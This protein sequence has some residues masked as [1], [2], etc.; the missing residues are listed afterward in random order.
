MHRDRK[1]S[2]G[3]WIRL[4]QLR[5][6][7]TG[8]GGSLGPLIAAELSDRLR[9]NPDEAEVRL[10]YV[11]RLAA[12]QEFARVNLINAVR[13]F[14]ADTVLMFNG[15]FVLDEVILSVARSEGL[16]VLRYEAGGDLRGFDLFTHSANDREALQRRM[17]PLIEIVRS[18]PRAREIGASWFETRV[19]QPE[20]MHARTADVGLTGE[21]VTF[22]TSSPDEF[23]LTRPE[24]MRG[25]LS[26]IDAIRAVRDSLATNG[27]PELVVRTH[28]N[29]RNKSPL[30]RKAWS[31]SLSGLTGIRV[32]D[33]EQS[34]DSYELAR[35]SKWV[36][37]YGS[38]IG[39][40]AMYLGLP[41]ITMGSSLYSSLIEEPVARSLS[42]LRQIL[43]HPQPVDEHRV[44]AYGL[45]MQVRGFPFLRYERL[46]HGTGQLLGRPLPRFG[47]LSNFF[48][49]INQRLHTRRVKNHYVRPVA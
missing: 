12:E 45:F 46:G 21:F 43:R 19:R 22:F 5:A 4:S 3:E 10:S 26:Q 33:E 38:T 6:G 40:E 37:T 32:I 16:D 7:S 14:Q 35:R 41:T 47:R 29:M 24:E 30:E 49:G 25:Y 31:R 9:W 17:V 27:S 13:M 48:P 44:L 39:V 8:I 11:E 1:S 42:D 23:F 2:K 34:I 36:I 20:G 18:D 15:R 28:P